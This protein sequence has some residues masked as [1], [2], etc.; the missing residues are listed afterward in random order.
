M[1][2][3]GKVVVDFVRAP[4][5]WTPNAKGFREL[6]QAARGKPESLMA[7]ATVMAVTG[8]REK[9]FDYLSKALADD[10]IEVALEIRYPSLDFRPPLRDC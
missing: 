1:N 9:A 7:V 6:A 10:E 3:V 5:L 2:S 8:E 4:R